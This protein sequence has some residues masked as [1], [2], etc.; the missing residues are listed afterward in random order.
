MLSETYFLKTGFARSGGFKFYYFPKENRHGWIPFPEA[1]YS[2][3]AVWQAVVPPPGGILGM[4]Y[5]APK[6]KDGAVD[7]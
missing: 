2:D 1:A 4:I 6:S 5:T 3:E 7:W